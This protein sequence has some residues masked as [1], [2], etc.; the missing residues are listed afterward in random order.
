MLSEWVY[1]GEVSFFI[2]TNPLLLW[3]RFPV[4]FPHS[5]LLCTVPDRKA[6]SQASQLSHLFWFADLMDLH[7]EKYTRIKPTDSRSAFAGH[8]TRTSHSTG[9][10][11]SINHWL[12]NTVD[13]C[14]VQRVSLSHLLKLGTI[15][16]LRSS[17]R[18][19][20]NLTWQNTL[21]VHIREAD[22]FI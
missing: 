4:F 20:Q 1:L 7:G 21:V 13:L 17:L 12:K 6:M 14:C 2:W 10:Q 18:H 16:E 19:L 11:D 8:F 5:L 22:Y 15:P 9:S 3:G